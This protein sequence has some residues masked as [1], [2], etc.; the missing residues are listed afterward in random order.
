KAIT[1]DN[2]RD[3]VKALELMKTQEKGLIPARLLIAHTKRLL[4]FFVSLKQ[5]ERLEEAQKKLSISENK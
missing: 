2:A 4:A 1:T 5:S 3:M